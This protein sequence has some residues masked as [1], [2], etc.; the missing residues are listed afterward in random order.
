MREVEIRGGASEFSE[1][2]R[3]WAGEMVPVKMKGVEVGEE[4]EAAR[5]GSG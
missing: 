3:D 4:R 5:N 1:G 2:I